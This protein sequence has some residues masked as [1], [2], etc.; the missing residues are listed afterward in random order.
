MS[1]ANLFKGLMFLH[2]YVNFADRDAVAALAPGEQEIPQGTRA[3]EPR[4][5]DSTPIAPVACH[6]H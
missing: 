3:A 4:T 2:G 1:L 6:A 5:T